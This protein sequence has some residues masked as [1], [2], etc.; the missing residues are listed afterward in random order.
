MTSAFFFLLFT[1]NGYSF[2][3]IFPAPE[4]KP[5]QKKKK[6]KQTTLLKSPPEKDKTN[7][8]TTPSENKAPA[9]KK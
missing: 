9:S 5:V 4:S 1:E 8:K 2:F 6:G 3:I 7:E